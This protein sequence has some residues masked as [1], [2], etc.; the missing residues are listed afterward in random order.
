[1]FQTRSKQLQTVEKSTGNCE[2]FFTKYSV[3]PN[4]FEIVKSVVQ[5][6][7]RSGLRLNQALLESAIKGNSNKFRD[8]NIQ[9]IIQEYYSVEYELI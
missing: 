7:D 3:A 5:F 4:P 2:T 9:C 8:T 6:S 1:M